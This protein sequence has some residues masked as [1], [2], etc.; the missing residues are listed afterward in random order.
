MF[1][2]FEFKIRLIRLEFIISKNKTFLYLKCQPT[3]S[4]SGVITIT[5][6]SQLC[7]WMTQKNFQ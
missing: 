3:D 1:S 6:Q 4:Q 7:V 2:D 5:P